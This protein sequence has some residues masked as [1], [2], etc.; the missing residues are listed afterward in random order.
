MKNIINKE[1]NRYCFISEFNDLKRLK[2]NLPKEKNIKFLI[3]KI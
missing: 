1:I 3:R 2:L